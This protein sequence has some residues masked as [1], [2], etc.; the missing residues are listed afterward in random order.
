MASQPGSLY[1]VGTR[2]YVDSQ[3]VYN[4]A[5]MHDVVQLP[6]GW[7]VLAAGGS[8]RC[9]VVEGRPALPGQRG[10]LYELAAEG[11]VN[12]KAQRGAW[13]SRNLVRA[14]GRF[15]SW[16]GEPAAASACGC[17][18][19]ACACGPCRARHGQDHDDHGETT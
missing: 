16:P 18:A 9:A 3:A 11:D 2:R 15:E 6:N 17:I 5:G 12:L 7:R 10:A 14:A 8:V 4:L 13:L 1:R 19:K